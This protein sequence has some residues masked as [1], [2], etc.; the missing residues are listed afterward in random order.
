MRKSN[1]L[2]SWLEN[3]PH[4]RAKVTCGIY[5]FFIERVMRLAW[6]F[7]RER[8]S[9]KTTSPAAATKNAA[10]IASSPSPPGLGFSADS[11]TTFVGDIEIFSGTETELVS[12]ARFVDAAA[13]GGFVAS[14]FGAGDGG[15]VSA[16]VPIMMIDC[17]TTRFG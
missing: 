4:A 9:I 17:I 11:A 2:L 10:P 13:N 5:F 15:F 6:L 12:A 16:F 14:N 1:S 3:F 8:R 7:L